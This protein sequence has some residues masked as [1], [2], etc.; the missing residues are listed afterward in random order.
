MLGI[1][2]TRGQRRARIRKYGG[3]F[4]YL[5]ITFTT[6]AIGTLA[7]IG[8]PFLAGYYSKDLILE[9]AYSSSHLGFAIYILASM[10]AFLTSFYSLRSIYFVFFGKSSSLKKA[11]LINV[12]ESAAQMTVPM[13]IL[14]LFAIFS[15]Y[16]F[17]DI[18][19]GPTSLML[20]GNAIPSNIHSSLTEHEYIPLLYKLM[21]TFLGI[22]GLLTSYLYF[23]SEKFYLTML[24]LYSIMNLTGQKFYIDQLYNLGISKATTTFGYIQYTIF[25]RGYLEKMGP[26]GIIEVIA[27]LQK[28]ISMQS[29]FIMHYLLIFFTSILLIIIS[30]YLQLTWF[31][32]TCLLLTTI[33][34]PQKTNH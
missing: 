24:T 14:S 6:M 15:G 34:I 23:H 2:Y 4:T 31:T 12:H 30:Y 33:I 8:A 27:Y 7:L 18:L 16:I 26:N 29:G 13:I 28:K 19:T 22:L 25:D 20:W 21:P 3:L 10:A 11:T 9:T 32:T 17:K 1:N 5:P